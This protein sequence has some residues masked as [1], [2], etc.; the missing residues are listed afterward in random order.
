M[1]FDVDAVWMHCMVVNSKEIRRKEERTHWVQVDA[2]ACRRV[3]CAC[4]W[5]QMVM[6]VVRVKKKERDKKLTEC[7]WWTQLRV[8]ALHV[9]M[10]SMQM[11]GW[12]RMRVKKYEK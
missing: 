8:E 6:D 1:A 11:L 3:A 9:C 4:A 10:V 7:G 5:T 2:V 12:A